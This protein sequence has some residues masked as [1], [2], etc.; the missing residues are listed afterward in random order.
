MKKESD[1]T[2][3]DQSLGV[4]IGQT[5]ESYW[6]LPS[7]SQITCGSTDYDGHARVAIVHELRE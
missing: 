7:G 3:V 4:A 6:F 2:L 1:A 5:W